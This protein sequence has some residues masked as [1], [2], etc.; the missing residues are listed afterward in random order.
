MGNLFQGRF[1]AILVERDTYLLEIA[2][3]LA[4]NPVRDG[5]VRDAGDW[6]WSSYRGLKKLQT[7]RRSAA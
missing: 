6:L 1:R 7:R 2:R 4:L 5:M 3:Y